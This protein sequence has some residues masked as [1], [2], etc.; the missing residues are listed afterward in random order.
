MAQV[1]QFVER[2][3]TKPKAVGSIPQFKRLRSLRFQVK[4]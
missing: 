3:A 2:R 4:K 1:T